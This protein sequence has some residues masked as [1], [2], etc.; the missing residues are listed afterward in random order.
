MTKG[1]NVGRPSFGEVFSLVNSFHAKVHYA[2]AHILGHLDKE[3]V[4]EEHDGKLILRV[5]R[6]LPVEPSV[7]QLCF[8]KPLNRHVSLGQALLLAM[9][10]GLKPA[11]HHETKTALKAAV[12]EQI[13]ALFVH[14]DQEVRL[15]RLPETPFVSAACLASAVIG[16]TGELIPVQEVNRY[17]GWS[18]VQLRK[19]EFD[20]PLPPAMVLPFLVK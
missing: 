17:R 8:I 12:S 5:D 6:Q 19:L 10:Y 1:M 9:D 13:K 18:G 3:D 7:V 2:D 4:D 11:I 20:A 14:V 16:R 15:R